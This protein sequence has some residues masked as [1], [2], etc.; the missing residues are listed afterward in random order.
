[1]TFGESKGTGMGR[2][3]GWTVKPGLG[4]RTRDGLDLKVK[5]QRNYRWS[6]SRGGREIKSGLKP[7]LSQGI[8]RA[9]EAADRI[10]RD[11]GA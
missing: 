2:F 6:V 4:T 9:E 5:W 11:R 10:V 3:P 8:A 1:M 7:T